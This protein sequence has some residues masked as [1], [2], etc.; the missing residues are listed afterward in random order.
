MSA[1]TELKIIQKRLDPEFDTLFR[2][3]YALV[4]RTAYSVTGSVEDAEDVVQTIFLRLLRRAFPPDL[5]KNP[6]AYLYR[7]AFNAA[8]SVLRARRRQ[9]VVT[10]DVERLRA[11]A[12]VSE[13]AVI[14]D[15]HRQLYAAI[16]ELHPRSAQ[17]LIL[18]Y[19]HNFNLSDI[20]KTVGTTRGAVAISLFR[21]RARLKKLV[22]LSLENKQ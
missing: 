20:A 9:P 3:H 13:D 11:A 17:I 1:A 4:Y 10:N 7:A 19:V 6:R 2:A 15:L 14:E 16:A 12:A 8:L 22:R 21:S 5:K 18:R